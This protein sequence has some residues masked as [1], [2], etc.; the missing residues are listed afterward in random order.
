MVV[1]WNLNR[2]EKGGQVSVMAKAHTEVDIGR[3]R[4]SAF[5][6]TR[7]EVNTHF[8]SLKPLWPSWPGFGFDNQYK[9]VFTFVIIGCLRVRETQWVRLLV[10]GPIR[11]A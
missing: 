2:V 7:Y 6:D 4:I 5:D 1:I 8:K 9:L 11:A 3:M 10:C